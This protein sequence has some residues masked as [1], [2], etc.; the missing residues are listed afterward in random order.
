MPSTAARSSSSR[1]TALA[2]RVAIRSAASSITPCWLGA[3]SSSSLRKVPVTTPPA[4]AEATTTTSAVT[5]SPRR[6][7]PVRSRMRLSVRVP[8]AAPSYRVSVLHMTAER[9]VEAGSKPA[10]RVDGLA[11]VVGHEVQVTPGRV[12]G[13]ADVTDDL[14][15]GDPG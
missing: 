10:H 8:P 5:R 1:S 15:P 12:A 9:Q 6:S 11:V 4:Y 2:D 14:A 7:P 3:A 13:G